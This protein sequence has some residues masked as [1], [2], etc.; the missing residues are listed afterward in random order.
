LKINKTL[1]SAVATAMTFAVA[2]YRVDPQQ[3][4]LRDGWL[5]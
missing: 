2:D 5:S 1:V 4:C 3:Q